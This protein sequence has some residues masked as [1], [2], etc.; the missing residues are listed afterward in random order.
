VHRTLWIALVLTSCVNVRW[1]REHQFEAPA[2]EVLAAITTEAPLA[3]CLAR[4]GAPLLVWEEPGGAALA[5]GWFEGRTWGGGVSVPVTSFYSASFNASD[6]DRNLQGLVLIFDHDWS[7]RI[8]R[9]GQLRE[10]ASYRRRDP[11]LVE[12]E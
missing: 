1:Q 9:R 10:L 12:S 11:A 2:P 5:W 6:I 3:D 7:V 4:L 8:V